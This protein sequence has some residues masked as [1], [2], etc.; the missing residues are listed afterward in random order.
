MVKL[1]QQFIFLGLVSLLSVPIPVGAQTELKPAGQATSSRCE[2]A[3]AG[4]N[5]LAKVYQ[6]RATASEEPLSH[7][8]DR[9]VNVIGRAD[10]RGYDV[11]RLQADQAELEQRSAAIKADYTAVIAAINAAKPMC[12]ADNSLKPARDA[13]TKLRSDV[14]DLKQWRASTL[15]VDLAKLKAARPKQ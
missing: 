12:A 9:L 13:L 2:R 1:A 8:H 11:A 3:A 7:I 4:V 15:Q 5:T 10:A 6:E 14:S